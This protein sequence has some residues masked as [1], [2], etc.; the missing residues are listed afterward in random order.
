MRLSATEASREFSDLLSRVA[1]GESV[2]VERHGHVVAVVVPPSRGY[3]SGSSVLE[4]LDR[5]PLPDSDFGRDVAGLAEVL[6]TSTSP[7]P[8]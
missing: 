2:E 6:K 4:L 3:L 8:S 5:L 1:A 7:W